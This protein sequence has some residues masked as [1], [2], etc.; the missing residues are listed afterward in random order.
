MKLLSDTSAKARAVH[1]A[2]LR[3]K[4][5]EESFETARQLTLF[6]Q[7]LAFSN[8]RERNPDLSDDEIWLTLAS[9]RLGPD[10]VR[11]IYTQRHKAS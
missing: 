2:L 4:T 9:E 6:V 11:K 7:H 3:R 10:V 5:P 1:D 8:V